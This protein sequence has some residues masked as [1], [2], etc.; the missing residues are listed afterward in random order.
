MVQKQALSSTLTYLSILAQ[1]HPRAARN[2]TVGSLPQ[3]GATAPDI[4][5]D[6][7]RSSEML[8]PHR[9]RHRR[10][11]RS[12]DLTW[13]Q[14]VPAPRATC[15]RCVRTWLSP[16]QPFTAETSRLTPD[17]PSPSSLPLRMIEDTCSDRS[18]LVDF[19]AQFV[20][21]FETSAAT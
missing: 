20:K 3:A 16:E 14:S 12:S 13:Y 8:S 4:F 5:W 15:K 9:D 19:G 1:A 17:A 6:L 10:S 21:T 18:H 2:I 11:L 7:L